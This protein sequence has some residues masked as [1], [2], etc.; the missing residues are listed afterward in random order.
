MDC[1]CCGECSECRG[2]WIVDVIDYAKRMEHALLEMK[3]LADAG[4]RDSVQNVFID[5]A[6]AREPSLL[7]FLNKL[8]E[9]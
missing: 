7:T 8:L 9:A 6:P 1:G 4:E 3:R 5:S 2:R